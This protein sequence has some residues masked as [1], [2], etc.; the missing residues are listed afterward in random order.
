MDNDRRQTIGI[1]PELLRWPKSIDTYTIHVYQYNLETNP[2][3][4]PP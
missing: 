3:L 2:S 4:V 1:D